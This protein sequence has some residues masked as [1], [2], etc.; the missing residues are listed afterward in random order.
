[1]FKFLKKEISSGNTIRQ[2]INV[3]QG[4][5]R[6]LSQI[7]IKSVKNSKIKVQCS[8]W[9]NEIRVSGKKRDFQKS[10][11]LIKEIDLKFRTICQFSRLV[12]Q[13]FALLSL[14][15]RFV[16]DCLIKF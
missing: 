5:D 2:K 3:R 8:I 6:D 12:Q 14:F 4:I 7:I 1:M 16:I 13:D 9:G 15:P 11:Q 10:I